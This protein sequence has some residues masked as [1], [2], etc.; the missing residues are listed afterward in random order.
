M[1]PGDTANKYGIKGIKIAARKY[2]V[3][4]CCAK[5]V[6]LINALP[7]AGLTELEASKA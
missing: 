1:G 4:T 7:P 5:K 6:G 2:G 3:K